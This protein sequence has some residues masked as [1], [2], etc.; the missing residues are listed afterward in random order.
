MELSCSIVSS[1]EAEKG[2]YNEAKHCQVPPL[3]R[4]TQPYKVEQAYGGAA[5]GVGMA[6]QNPA[7][8][9]RSGTQGMS[10][11]ERE[12]KTRQF[13]PGSN[14]LSN[15]VRFPDCIVRNYL[16]TSG[17]IDYCQPQKISLKRPKKIVVH[18]PSCGL[19]YSSKEP[20]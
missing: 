3:H 17:T 8:G 20:I 13:L 12:T 14:I 2:T 1:V 15:F 19:T 16:P 5:L 11:S 9:G 10:E 6:E 7:R 18:M 4:L